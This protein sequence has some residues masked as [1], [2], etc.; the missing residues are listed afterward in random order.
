LRVAKNVVVVNKK[1]N[2][3]VSFM[4]YFGCDGRRIETT[5]IKDQGWQ[6]RTVGGAHGTGV[7][8]TQNS[9]LGCSTAL[10]SFTVPIKKN[11]NNRSTTH[12]VVKNDH[13]ILIIQCMLCCVARKSSNALLL[14]ESLGRR[15]LLT[16]C[17]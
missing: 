11:S 16:F 7:P 3:G 10:I 4:G 12:T 2:P 1:A 8:H 14:P 5:G 17:K 9:N 15:K 6:N 13:I